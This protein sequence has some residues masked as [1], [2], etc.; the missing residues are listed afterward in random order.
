MLQKAQ[1]TLR[2]REPSHPS[3]RTGPI[4]PRRC[5]RP[6][7]RADALPSRIA[8]AILVLLWSFAPAYLQVAGAAGRS[9]PQ[10]TAALQASSFQFATPVN[11]PQTIAHHGAQTSRAERDDPADAD[12]T[13]PSD[14]QALANA[15]FSLTADH[16]IGTLADAPQTHRATKTLRLRSGRAPPLALRAA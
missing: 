8:L 16:H 10:P 9:G 11:R 7:A 5:H 3:N 14:G 1:P 13:G 4:S 15:A 12:G 6:A 2:H